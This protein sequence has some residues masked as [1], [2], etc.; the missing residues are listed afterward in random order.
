M[1]IRLKIRLEKEVMKKRRVKTR[2]LK[3]MKMK[4]TLIVCIAMVC[5]VNRGSHRVDVPSANYELAHFSCPG[6]DEGVHSFICERCEDEYFS[7]LVTNNGAVL[8]IL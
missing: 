8:V 5:T 1:W 4:R 7:S 6:V 2:F 3:L